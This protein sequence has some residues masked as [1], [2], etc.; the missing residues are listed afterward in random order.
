M[1]T[2]K[3][4]LT[5]GDGIGPEVLREGVKAVRAAE[6]AVGGFTL[7]METYDIGAACYQRCGEVFPEASFRACKEADAIYFGCVGTPGVVFPDGTEVG[8]EAGLQMRFRFDLY[9]NIRPIKLYPNVPCRLS[10]KKAGDID[11]VIIREN[12]EGLYASRGG[13]SV[14]HDR[15]AV[16]TMVISRWETERISNVAFGLARSRAGAP[17]DKKKRVTCVD[18]ANILRSYSFFRK[19]FTET[20]AGYPEVEADYAYMDAMACWLVLKPEFYDVVVTENMFGDILT[21]LGAATVGG[22]GMSPSAEVGDDHGMFQGSHG[23]AP[24]IAGKNLANP[25]ATIVSGAMMLDWLAG[26]SGNGNLKTAADLIDKAVTA[27]YEDNI[28]TTDLGGSY[29]TSQF[30]EAVEK[31]ILTL[32][33]EKVL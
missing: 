22:M 13:G 33:V 10:G 23:S 18:K 28:L 27:V 6:K 1:T 31:K 11:Y 17:V 16:D 4:A 25:A 19:V 30:G 2:F 3:I 24:T 15:I 21:D 20:A 32:P 8:V 5:P 29:S 7:N 14:T 26:R 9:A 12:I